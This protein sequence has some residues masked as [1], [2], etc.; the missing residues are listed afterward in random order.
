MDARKQILKSIR[1]HEIP[2]VALPGLHKEWI[3]YEDPVGQLLRAL[4]TVGGKGHTVAK[5]ADVKKKLDELADF[6]Q[7]KKI[8][9][10]VG[11]LPSRGIDLEKVA[12][13]HDLAD[14]DWA[15]IPGEFA[16]AENGA[17]WVTDLPSIHRTLPFISQ[18][19]VILLPVSEVIDNMHQAYERINFAHGQRQFGVF[20]SGPSKTADIEQSLV[21]GAHGARSLNVFLIG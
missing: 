21:I 1:R 18:H 6:G 7:A 10:L 9:S 8:C 15:I 4:S 5:N 2:S 17:I 13:P 14:I 20:I 12:D 19:L 3:H 16:V 11:S